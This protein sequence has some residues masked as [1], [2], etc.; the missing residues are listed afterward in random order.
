VTDTPRAWYFGWNI[1][2]ASALITLLSVGMRL[3]MGPFFLPLTQ[4][5]GF[6][7]SLLASV[8]AVGMLFYGLAMPLAG[9][10]VAR[11][12]TR[13]VLSLGAAI[14]VVSA[15][16]SVNARDPVS[17]MLSFGAMLSVGL[18]FAS[19]VALTPVISHWFKRKRGMALFFLSTGS[20]AGMAIM[21]PV[22][23]LGIEAWGWRQTLLV[24][25]ALFACLTLV[26]AWFVMRDEAPEHADLL[27]DQIPAPGD[28]P[29]PPIVSLDLREVIRTQPFWLVF[30]GLFAC[31]YSMNLLGTHGMPMLMDHGFDAFSSS[32]GVGLI[33]LVAIAGTVMLGSLADR[34]P[35]RNLLAVIYGIR[36]LGFFALVAVGTHFELYLT[37]SIG[38]LVWA[39]S[40][41]LSSAILADVYGV[42]LVGVLYGLGY[43][44]HQLGGTLSSWLGGWGYETF[45]THWIAFGSAGVLLFVAAWLSL[46]LPLKGHTLMKQ[47]APAASLPH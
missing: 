1:V 42:R 18:A 36:G 12:S 30:L 44:G 20:M 19:P 43:L 26:A 32:M 33:G 14:V 27:A 11:Y 38:G 41:A 40:I 16:W 47:V 13:F 37:A 23:A 7:R 15:L 39:G 6:S 17:F 34:V 4:D 3:S 31:G 24:F 8:V 25:A 28:T 22:M 46:R 10:L 2:G 21:T 9:Y 45:G 35:R 29:A 5:M